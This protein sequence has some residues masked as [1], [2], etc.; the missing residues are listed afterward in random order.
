MRGYIQHIR[1]EGELTCLHF[2]KEDSLPTQI[3]LKGR[4]R[5]MMDNKYHA[6]YKYLVAVETGYRMFATTDSRVCL[7]FLN[8]EVIIEE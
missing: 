8:Y 7:K 6:D 5:Y 3:L 4:I 2:L 1:V